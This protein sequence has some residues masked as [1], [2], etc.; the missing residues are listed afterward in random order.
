MIITWLL[1]SFHI[2][3][4]SQ[5]L[6]KTRFPITFLATSRV[7][8]VHSSW[9]LTWVYNTSWLS[10]CTAEF[11][12]LESKLWH[13]VRSLTKCISSP[14]EQRCCMT[15]EESLLSCNFHNT[16]GLENINSCLISGPTLWS[17]LEVKKTLRWRHLKKK[18]RSSFVLPSKSSM[19]F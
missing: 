4:S 19:I 6:F 8:L 5:P 15:R 3:K 11:T 1:R 10:T 7:S 13:T 16:L 2:I 18:E 9:I 12:S 14:K 17:R